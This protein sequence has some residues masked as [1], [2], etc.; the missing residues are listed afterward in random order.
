MADIHL[1]MNGIDGTQ[2][3][4]RQAKNKWPNDFWVY[5]TQLIFDLTITGDHESAM[6]AVAHLAEM[7]PGTK[8]EA[9]VPALVHLKIG[10]EDEGIKY[11]TEFAERQFN[12]DG[13]KMNLFKRWF[14]NSSNWF[15]LGQD[16]QWLYRYLTYAELGRTDLA[17]IEID[18]FLRESGENGRKI[19]LELVHAAGIPISQEAYSGSSKHLDVTITQYLGHLAEAS[20]FKDFGLPE[21][22]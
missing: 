19:V 14:R 22:N 16:Q 12:Q 3:F 4:L 8:Y 5:D 17:K 7:E 2:R 15:V 6:A 20:G 9:L 11:V 1:E 13:A 21:K 10:N 18:E